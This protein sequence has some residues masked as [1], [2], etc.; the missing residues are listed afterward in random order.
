MATYGF[1]REDNSSIKSLISLTGSGYHTMNGVNAQIESADTVV[2]A[3]QKIYNVVGWSFMPG[4]ATR[5]IK[6]EIYEE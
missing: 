5:S 2:S 1:E 4:T 6:E 3:M